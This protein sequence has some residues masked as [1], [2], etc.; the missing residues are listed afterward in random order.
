MSRLQLVVHN[1]GS[2]QMPANSSNRSLHPNQSYGWASQMQQQIW[3]V[4]Q[5][6]MAL[7]QQKNR[8]PRDVWESLAELDRIQR[9]IHAH[10]MDSPFS[11]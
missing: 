11:P 9:E 4:Q 1:S 3:N 10:S 7:E 2:G 6:L 8:V 5:F